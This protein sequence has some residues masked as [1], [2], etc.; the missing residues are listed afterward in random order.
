M[1][2]CKSFNASGY[3]SSVSNDDQALAESKP[4]F[5][6]GNVSLM[7]VFRSAGNRKIQPVVQLTPQSWA[8]PAIDGVF[9]KANWHHRR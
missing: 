8:Q 3:R 1:T 4:S 2:S 5:A 6:C 7:A 9:T